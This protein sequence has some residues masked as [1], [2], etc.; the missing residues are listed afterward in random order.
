M[1]VAPRKALSQAYSLRIQA[2]VG[3][4]TQSARF[5]SGKKNAAKSTSPNKSM[6]AVK[7]SPDARAGA[8][9]G[10]PSKADGGGSKGK[11]AAASKGGGGA[12]GEMVMTLRGVGKTLPGGRILF[13]DVS[14]GFQRGAKIG[15]LGLNGA[16]KSS[17][18]KIVAGQDTEHDGQV[19]RQEGLKVGY[20]AQEPTLDASKDV[21]GNIMDGLADVT[22]MLER[23]VPPTH[24]AMHVPVWGGTLGLATEDNQ[25]N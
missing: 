11:G 25:M 4:G 9:R 7:S 6:P 18:L 8:S 2:V 22:A 24:L 19:W 15:V 20:L 23:Y 5:Q 21:H 13:K 12:E 3:G 1:F 17:L 14:L 10:A 16:G